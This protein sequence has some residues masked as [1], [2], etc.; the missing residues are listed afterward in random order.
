MI[1]ITQRK[2]V[3][4][5]ESTTPEDYKKYHYQGYR[6]VKLEASGVNLMTIIGLFNSL[7][8]I[9]GSPMIWP[10]PWAKL[11]LSNLPDYRS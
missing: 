3:I 4:T 9:V 8:Y 7:P 10:M 6:V 1:I 2:G 11:I 5:V